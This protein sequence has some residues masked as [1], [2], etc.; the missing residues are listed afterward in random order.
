[1]TDESG[2]L[3]AAGSRP[4]D[5]LVGPRGKLGV[6][7]EGLG[8]AARHSTHRARDRA[9]DARPTVQ[10]FALPA[11]GSRRTWSVRGRL[12]TRRCPA[13]VT[14]V[15]FDPSPE[16]RLPV[17]A[18]LGADRRRQPCSCTTCC[19]TSCASGR[20]LDRAYSDA[21]RATR[22][23][24]SSPGD[25]EVV[26]SRGQRV[27][28][29]SRAPLCVADRRDQTSQVDA[30][31]RE[32][33]RHARA[34]SSSDFHVHQ[35]ASSDS[36]IN[37]PASA[38][39]SSRA[40]AWTTSSRPTTTVTRTSI[41]RSRSSVSRTS[42]TRPSGEEITT[43]DYGHFNAYP[44]GRRPDAADRGLDRLAAPVPVARRRGNRLP[45][46]RQLHGDAGGDRSARG[47]RSDQ[48]VPRRGRAD[49][50]LRQPLRTAQDRHRRGAAELVPLG[51]RSRAAQV[52]SGFR[53]P[54]P[55]VRRARAVERLHARPPE[56]LPRRADRS[57]DEPAQPGDPDDRDLRHRHPR[58]LQHPGRGARAAGRLRCRTIRRRSSTTR[59][60]TT[61]SAAP[62]TADAWSAARAS[63]SRRRSGR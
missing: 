51:R 33:D 55:P 32:G 36:R 18:S 15:G 5:Y 22:P 60:S 42:S 44:L 26:V 63:T 14:I 47:R 6:P 2:L 1:M 39:S 50:P 48:H 56:R 58:L 53:E 46:A 17:R 29:T 37:A 30:T 27:L 8:P 54:L 11:T 31:D 40:R 49:Q 21:T 52:R 10:D 38:C 19:A 61:R 3:R 7:Y 13:R 62:S 35:I 23:S 25:Y 41:P 28:R 45:V 57:L 9:T 59:R 4:G 34:S 24:T 12:R 16:I 43:F 20:R